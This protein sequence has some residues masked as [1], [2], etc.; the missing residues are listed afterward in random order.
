MFL[1]NNELEK[2][3]Y[4]LKGRLNHTFFYIGY[5]LYWACRFTQV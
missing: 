5:D 1:N 3:Q 2:K 4:R